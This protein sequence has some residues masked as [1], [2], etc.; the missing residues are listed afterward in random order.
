VRRRH[1]CAFIVHDIA[2]FQIPF[3]GRPL[4]RRVVLEPAAYLRKAT[5]QVVYRVT[6]LFHLL[7]I[8]VL[9]VLRVML[10]HEKPDRTL[11][12]AGLPIKL[13]ARAAPLL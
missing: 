2:L 4:V 1:L 6:L 13:C 8:G 3:P 5:L 10:L 11:N 12:P 7:R 9:L